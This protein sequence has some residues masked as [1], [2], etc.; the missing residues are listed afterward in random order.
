MAKKKKKKRV[1]TVSV[2]DRVAEHRKRM[3][4]SG[5]RQIAVQLPESVI[6]K[7]DRLC[8]TK[9]QN[10]ATVLEQLIKKA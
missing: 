4:E 9:E 10:R 2:N 5:Y 6:R 7:L 1:K 3:T 8:K